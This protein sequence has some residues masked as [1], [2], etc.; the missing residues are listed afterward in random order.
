MT[1]VTPIAKKQEEKIELTYAELQNQAFIGAIRKLVNTELPLQLGYKLSRI[2][3]K[4]ESESKLAQKA[5]A[6]IM[7]KRIEWNQDESGKKTTP[8][9]K[10]A[11][12]KLLAEWMN[13]KF[14]FGKWTKIYVQDLHTA[15]LT[16]LE[17]EALKPILSGLETL[18]EGKEN[19]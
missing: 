16:P 19:G 7:E 2:K 11:A 12:D 15:K 1:N 6:E 8:K 17:L 13:V 18:E 9:D 4:L 14:D 5:W 10:E 3:D